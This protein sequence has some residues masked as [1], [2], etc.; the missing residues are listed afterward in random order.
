MAFFL[1]R[2]P[3]LRPRVVLE[4]PAVREL[5]LRWWSEILVRHGGG[6]GGHYF[7][8]EAA[9]I[10]WQTPQFILRFPY[11]GVDFRGDPDTILPLGEVFDHRGM[12]RIFVL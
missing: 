7:I 2:V 6:E 3:A 8:E 10:W 9:L 11:A 5:R 1:E 4:V 12:S